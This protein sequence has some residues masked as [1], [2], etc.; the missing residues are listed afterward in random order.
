MSRKLS[1]L[2]FG[3]LVAAGCSKSTPSGS[4]GG[5]SDS[6]SPEARAEARKIF[7]QRCTPCHGPMGRGDGPASASLNPHPRNFTDKTWQGTVT[8]EHIQ[9][10]IQYGG[11]AVGKS[12]NMPANPDLQA[13]PL[14]VQALAKK[15]RTFAQ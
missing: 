7:E 15:I 14:V 12:P 6:I 11:A 9:K 10:I 13:K 8:D 5:G 4:A 2:L 1:Y 3:L